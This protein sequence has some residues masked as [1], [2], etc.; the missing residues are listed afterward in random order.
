MKI[1]ITGLHGTVA[2]VVAT[3]AALE[4]HIVVPLDRDLIDIDN[5]QVLD[6]FIKEV[7][8]DFIFHIG[9]GSIVFTRFLVRAAK[10]YHIK[11]LYTST[12]MVFDGN[13]QGPFDPSIIP[14][15]ISEY[16]K[17]KYES[18]QVI[19]DTLKDAYIVRL[20]W[21]IGNNTTGNQM[22]AQL[23]QEYLEKGYNEASEQ[24][25]LACSFITE[26]AKA[27][28][29]II[30]EK[31]GIYHVDQNHH[32]SMADILRYLKSIH[33]WITPKIIKSQPYNNQ[34]KDDK[35]TIQS[36]KDTNKG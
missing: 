22:I 27:I 36:L 32:L 7:N 19:L 18:E 35:L 4:G 10:K 15:P 31:P 9:M 17:Y 13:G 1:L 25:Y 34:M 33:P 21:Q 12:V 26:S 14:T 5:E 11:F 2:P 29:S 23:K 24:V 3:H 20:G 16:G 28:L 6:N 30:K 8:P